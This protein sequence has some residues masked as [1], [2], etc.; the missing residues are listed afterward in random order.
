MKPR[1]SVRIGRK[2]K[3]RGDDAKKPAREI[4]CDLRVLPSPSSLTVEESI[5]AQSNSS[6]GTSPSGSGH[7][8]SWDEQEQRR[9]SIVEVFKHMGSPPRES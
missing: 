2:F 1:R 8:M 5:A 9:I 3:Q 4:N 7:S 6:S